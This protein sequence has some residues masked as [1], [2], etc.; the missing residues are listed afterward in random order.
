MVWVE[1]HRGGEVAA[2]G[3]TCLLFYERNIPE[4]FIY[5]VFFRR[6]KKLKTIIDKITVLQE[7]LGSTLQ[8]R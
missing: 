3:C 8:F 6:F 1:G 7:Q 5:S 4:I 2:P